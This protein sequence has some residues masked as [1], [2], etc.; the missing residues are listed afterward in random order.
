MSS[1]TSFIM[2]IAKLS[3]EICGYK[4]EESACLEGLKH[5]FCYHEV[6]SDTTVVHRVVVCS[7]G[8]F[9]MTP[10]ASFVL[11]SPCLG[12]SGQSPNRPSFFTRLFSRHKEIPQYSGTEE[13]ACYRDALSHVDY[14]VP[15]HSE[16][17]IA[18]HA[19]EHVTYVFHDGPVTQSDG[20]P[21]MLL[22]VIGSQYGCYLMFASCVCVN[23]EAMLFMGNGGIGKSTLCLNLMKQGASYMGDDM[24][25]VYQEGEQLM[26]GALLFPLKCYTSKVQARK[27]IV[28]GVSL[29][30]QRPLLAVP[31]KH[32]YLLHRDESLTTAS[33]EQVKSE[34]RFEQIIKK[35]NKVNTHADGRHFFSTI[36]Y[37]SDTVPFCHLYYGDCNQI[38]T[39]FFIDNDPR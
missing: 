29:S 1:S 4:G 18:H 27:N 17:R 25:L 32:I 22:H 36:S 20:L 13:V 28:D 23:G 11:S 33:S 37:I 39:S 6:A 30:Q 34:I 21:S 24:V 35:T 3:I 9:K 26:T 7:T 38:T 12:L 31:L 16:W 15:E 5:L 14:W 10:E 19:R 8:Q 2:Q